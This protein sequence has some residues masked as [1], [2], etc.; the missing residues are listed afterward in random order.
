MA[1]VG[2]AGAVRLRTIARR[3]KK[4]TVSVEPFSSLD[5]QGSP[6]YNASQD[7]DVF[8]IEDQTGRGDHG[9]VV[10]AEGSEIRVSL[11][12]WVP[13]DESPL[14][15]EQD[16]ITRSGDTF[17]VEATRVAKNLR[18]ASIDHVKA[19]CRDE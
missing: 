19:M 15:G 16:R 12:L 5:G 9:L 11:V 14:P 13:G 1:C 7:I 2:R 8:V 6:S 4:E 3:A 10:S 17:I 18:S